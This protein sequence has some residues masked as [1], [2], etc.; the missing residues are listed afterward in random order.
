M[1]DAQAMEGLQLDSNEI[2][3]YTYGAFANIAELYKADR[4]E[5]AARVLPVLLESIDSKDGE[6]VHMT[7]AEQGDAAAGLPG[8]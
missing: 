6:G 7:Q 8:G 5:L 4:P 1:E 3:E 2:R